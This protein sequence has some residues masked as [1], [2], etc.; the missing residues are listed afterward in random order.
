MEMNGAKTGGRWLFATVALLCALLSAPLAWAQTID[1]L[2][3][4]AILIDVNTDTLLLEKNADQRM[5]TSSMSKVLT[6]YVVFS[7]LRAGTLKL[8]D[9]FPVSE[10]AWRM[11]GSKMFVELGNRIAVEDLIRGV[12]IQSGNDATVVLAEGIAGSEEAFAE[13]LNRAAE[14]LGMHDSHFMN[15]S[16]WPDPQHYSTARDLSRLALATIREFPEYY[17]YYS[18]LDFTYH[19]IKQQNRNPLLYRNMG[20]D[21]LKTGHTEDAGYGLIGTSVRDG[22]RL[23]AVVNGLTSVRERS[24]QAERLIDWGFREFRLVTLF[25]TQQ[26][27]TTARTWLGAEDEVPLVVGETLQM[28][29]HRRVAESLRGRVLVQEP[30]NTPIVKGQPLGTLILEADDMPSRQVP[31]VAGADV[32][33]LGFFGRM[34]AGLTYLASGAGE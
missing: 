23:L 30:I 26:P 1:T 2:A 9:T 18:E 34:L 21:G 7:H 28:A 15:A 16:G 11:Q 12:L 17:H 10:K 25:D 13:E 3:K 32:E 20:A 19:G 27:V 6:M 33:R 22:R 24:E 4:Q 14:K 31:L 5:P 8:T 29:V